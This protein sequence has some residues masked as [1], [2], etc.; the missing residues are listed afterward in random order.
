MQFEPSVTQPLKLTFSS[1]FAVVIFN[2]KMIRKHF[3][4][5]AIVE[6]LITIDFIVLSL[7]QC[8]YLVP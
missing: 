5:C 8:Y 3:C 4:Q 2:V 1:I 6:Y 7:A